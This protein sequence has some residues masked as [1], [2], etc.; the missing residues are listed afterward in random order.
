MSRFFLHR[1]S[2]KLVL[3]MNVLLVLT[4]TFISLI[5]YWNSRN[6]IANHVRESS[7]QSAKQTADYMSLILTVGIDMGQ[8]ISRD[9]MIQKVI[10]DEAKEDLSIDQKYG[11]KETV[12]QLLNNV[13]YTNT[14]VRSIYLLKEE[15]DSWGSGLFNISKVR[16]YTLNETS[17]YSDIVN[18][19]VDDTW[20]QL[21]YDPFSGGGENTDLVLTYVKT[22]R[23][24]QTRETIGAIVVNLNGQVILQAIE[25]IS[26]GKTG[27]FFI[28]NNAGDIM[29]DDDPSIYSQDLLASSQWQNINLVHQTEL[30]FELDIDDE[31]YYVVTQK[32]ENDWMIIGIV[33]VI[34]IIS[35]IQNIQ[36]EIWLYATI[37]LLISSIVGWLFSRRIT[38]PLKRLMNQ[39][40]QITKSNF[41][42][43]TEV[44]SQDEV[45]Q[46]SR[47]YNQMIHQIEMLIEQVNEVESKKR[48]AEMRALRHQ[49]NPH[50]LYNTLSTIRWMVKFKHYEKA[51]NAI[52]AL[53]QLMEASMEKK[54]PFI[55]IRDEIDLLEKY[56]VIQKFRYGSH[57]E[58]TITCDE[59]CYDYKIPR[60]LLQPLVENAIFHGIA[61][62]EAAGQIE[63]NISLVEGVKPRIFILIKDDGVGIPAHVMPGLL[64]PSSKR[65]TGIMYG[66]GLNH[67]HETIQLHY[68]SQSGVNIQSVPNQGT[69]IS[70]ELE[71]REDEGDA[72]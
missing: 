35:D 57:I 50:F 45:G 58:L 4:I 61:P 18:N 19:Q 1:L 37:F 11:I 55:T 47:K 40:S 20:L 25:R 60:M 68:G 10:Q 23:N 13:M 69:V 26:L 32:M 41:E 42:A 43:L 59:R 28:I 51:Y 36:R 31:R 66:I 2:T 24:I 21:Q 72:I 39:M 16:R 65:Q 6:I 17:W 64:K 9:A 14:F 8:Q 67:V 27:K 70:L 5:Y 3:T 29:I 53:V 71:N 7:R 48:E 30:E 46:L 63:V 62:K 49:I 38:S 15:G 52:A 44:T 54:G 34:E 56:M 12:D 22:L 33:P